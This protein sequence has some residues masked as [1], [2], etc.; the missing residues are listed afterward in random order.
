MGS[1]KRRQLYVAMFALPALMVSAAFAAGAVAGGAG[2]LWIFV[3]G[4]NPWPRGTGWVLAI[5]GIIAFAV[6]W[7]MLLAL[8]HAAGRREEQAPRLNRAHV[9]IAVA[10][11]VVLAAS[12]FALWK[13]GTS[14][15]ASSDEEVCSAFCRSEGFSASGMPPKNSGDRTCSCYDGQGKETRDVPLDQIRRRR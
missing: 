6:V 1:M 12:G 14:A 9:T 13:R 2:L 5:I 10:L 4:D 8:A 7:A 15:R 11:T 3:F